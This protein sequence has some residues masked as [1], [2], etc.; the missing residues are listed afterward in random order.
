MVVTPADHLVLPS[1]STAYYDLSEHNAWSTPDRAPIV[2]FTRLTPSHRT[3]CIVRVFCLHTAMLMVSM[4]SFQPLLLSKSSTWYT[5]TLFF[6]RPA[7]SIH[8]A[9]QNN[10]PHL[11]PSTPIPTDI[12]QRLPPLPRRLTTIPPRDL[13]PTSGRLHVRA[14][15]SFI[16][17]FRRAQHI[18]R[19]VQCIA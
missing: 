6:P 5:Q 10:P 17:A 14:I 8:T 9:Q 19:L 11:Y 13:L 18:Q 2:G 12:P 1:W 7:A 15:I 3:L 4:P 16:S